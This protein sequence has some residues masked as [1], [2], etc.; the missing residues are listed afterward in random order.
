MQH[1]S[2]RY[3]IALPVPVAIALAMQQ[4]CKAAGLDVSWTP[5]D[6]MH[7]TLNYF[8]ALSDDEL[9][10]ISRNLSLTRFDKVL[11]QVKKISA[12]TSSST[13]ET[14][15]SAHL[16]EIQELQAL[17]DTVASCA[18]TPLD[19]RPYMAHVTI[20]RSDKAIEAALISTVETS[21]NWIWAPT[22]MV[23]YASNKSH[24]NQGTPYRALSRFPLLN[25]CTP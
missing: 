22:E 21:P 16:P 2:E 1:K 10:I 17:R 19:S 20:G 9:Q 8:G 18:G 25:N 14:I 7:L 13:G 12:F 5:S 3:F 11:L 15:L 23:L 24:D 6:E 4:V